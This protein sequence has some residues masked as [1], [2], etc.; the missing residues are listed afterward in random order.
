MAA[1]FSAFVDQH[2]LQAGESLTLVLESDD[3][4]YFVEPDISPLKRQFEL[5]ASQHHPL[6]Q[7]EQGSVTQWHLTL[8]P[9]GTGSHRIPALSLGEHSTTPL[10]L[11]VHD[12][13][14]LASA[15]LAPVY[16]DAHVD[17]D[18]P[19]LHA[20]VL[21]TIRVY[22]STPLYADGQLSPLSMESARVEP[23]GEPKILEQYIHGIRHGVIEIRYA[24]F[25]QTTGQLLIP[26]QAFSATLAGQDPTS[27][28]APAEHKPG[29]KIEVRTTPITLQVQPPPADYP[30]EALWL[31]AQQLTLQ[32]SLSHTGTQLSLQHALGRTL[33]LNAIGLPSTLL[34]Q[35]LPTQNTGF[36]QYDNPVVRQQS[37][38]SQGLVSRL[39]EQQLLVA[40][41]PGT[42]ALAGIE[43]PWWDT[44]NDRLA[45]AR[46]P[47]HPLQ[48]SAP[49]TGF[50]SVFPLP[51]ALP[52]PQ[53]LLWWQ[54]AVLIL[55]L[56]CLLLWVLWR[57]ARGLPAVTANAQFS[58]AALHLE[59]L[60]RACLHNNPADARAALDA[61]ARQYATTPRALSEQS[62][63]LQQ[64]LQSLNQSL[65][66]QAEQPWQGLPLW[67]AINSLALEHDPRPQ[68]LPPLYPP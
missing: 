49:N 42:Y 58:S 15:T 44:E 21:L 33:T 36:T 38:S 37:S 54:L 22:H 60:R 47:A 63:V 16:I 52:L 29:H 25:P 31:P 64:A 17:R 18:T 45:Y 6:V 23:L 19:Y 32:Q 1:R 68:Q 9:K 3:P 24:I 8:R 14:N 27:L 11:W 35:L 50:N 65:Y 4:T 10:T 5:L 67:Q 48:I 28:D 66:A 12:I 34:P 7:T 43:L 30:S 41:Q 56:A 46:I 59:Q 53:E 39:E 55:S 57:R 13:P 20:Q 51:R 62:A 2:E 61:W 26:E 40:Q